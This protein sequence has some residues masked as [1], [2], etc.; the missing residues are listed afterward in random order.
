M[1][2]ITE[3]NRALA[4]TTAVQSALSLRLQLV[5]LPLLRRAQL[6]NC[7]LE[8][9]LAEQ[10]KLD[11]EPRLPRSFVA[12]SCGIFLKWTV[13]CAFVAQCVALMFHTPCGPS[14]MKKHPKRT[15]LTRTKGLVVVDRSGEAVEF[16]RVPLS[17]RIALRRTCCLECEGRR[18]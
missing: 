3:K 6:V 7:L 18:E 15:P 17:E 12:D 2:S 4:E 1:R 8:R 9:T 5:A 10:A 13:S 11:E 16:R 14:A